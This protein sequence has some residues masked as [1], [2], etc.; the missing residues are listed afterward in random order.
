MTCVSGAQS[1]TKHH[2]PTKGICAKRVKVDYSHAARITY[3]AK[4]R[5]V[6]NQEYRVI[7]HVLNRPIRPGPGICPDSGTDWN[8]ACVTDDL[9]CMIYELTVLVLN[10]S[11][12]GSTITTN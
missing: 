12:A 5:D 8:R 4:P 6:M 2:L 10:R 1:A 3:R 11:I 9:R 7:M